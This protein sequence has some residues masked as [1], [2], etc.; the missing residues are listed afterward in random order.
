L[1][2]PA[3]AGGGRGGK[4]AVVPRDA[5]YSIYLVHAHV[6]LMTPKLFFHGLID[7]GIPLGHTPW[8]SWPRA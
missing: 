4:G 6:V 2:S 8:R 5:S 7:L 1:L 3:Q